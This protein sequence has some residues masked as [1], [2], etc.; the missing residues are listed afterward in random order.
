M[1]YNL[2]N[3]CGGVLPQIRR[4]GRDFLCKVQ[5]ST[6]VTSRG[7]EFQLFIDYCKVGPEGIVNTVLSF[8]TDMIKN[9]FKYQCSIWFVDLQTGTA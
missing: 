3:V 7:V 9:N 5:G 6:H 2:T 4:T 1:N 8:K